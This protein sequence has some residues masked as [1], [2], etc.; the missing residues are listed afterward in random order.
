MKKSG[1]RVRVSSIAS[2]PPCRRRI[3]DEAESLAPRSLTRTF[4]SRGTFDRFLVNT[5]RDDDDD[6][7]ATFQYM[8]K[9]SPAWTWK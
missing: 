7:K 1:L 6:S 4:V 2:Y 8:A 9:V 3:P 5:A